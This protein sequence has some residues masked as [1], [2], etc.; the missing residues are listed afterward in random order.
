VWGN[1][2]PGHLFNRFDFFLREFF[3]RRSLNVKQLVGRRRAARAGF[4]LVELLVVIVIIAGLIAL[5]FPAVQGARATARRATSQSNLRQIALAALNYEAQNGQFPHAGRLGLNSTV[6]RIG[7]IVNILPQLER[8]DLYDRYDFAQ[9]WYDTANLP[10]TQARISVLLDPSSPLADRL[11]SRPESWGITAT[12]TPVSGTAGVVAVTDY[13]S[14]RQVDQ[15][16]FDGPGSGTPN[17]TLTGLVAGNGVK[18]GGTYA[19]G[20]TLGAYV[21]A[22]GAGIFPPN[23]ASKAGDV[24][25]GLSKTILIAE[26]HG[27]PYLYRR[28][29]LVSSDLSA[30]AAVNGGGWSRNANDIRLQGFNNDGTQE[31][32]QYGINAANGVDVLSTSSNRQGPTQYGTD[33]TGAIYSFHA[34]GA[35]VAFGD[36]S[37][38]FLSEKIDIAILAALVTRDQNE[39]YDEKNIDAR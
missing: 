36:A 32:G 12:G 20:Q 34:G 6:P 22:Y 26:S 25:D 19:S 17:T 18:T 7:W 31:I 8:K 3:M 14:I 27:R 38:K 23:Q 10:T 4:T 1:V 21:N 29:K 13:A 24:R 2:L 11:D 39:Y 35:H 9:N 5:A 37:V 15:R 30:G 28:G 33:G 16:L